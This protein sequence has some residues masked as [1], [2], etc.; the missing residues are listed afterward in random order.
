MP[1]MIVRYYMHEM[2]ADL[3]QLLMLE[4]LEFVVLLLETIHAMYKFQGFLVRR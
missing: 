4:K 1:Q 2:K 3:S